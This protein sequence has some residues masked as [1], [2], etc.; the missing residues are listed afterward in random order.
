MKTR[1][2][3]IIVYAISIFIAL[4]QV[5]LILIHTHLAVQQTVHSINPNSRFMPTEYNHAQVNFPIN[6]T[7]CF[8][9]KIVC[10]TASSTQ[11]CIIVMKD[12]KNADQHICYQ[13]GEHLRQCMITNGTHQFTTHMH[14]T[15]PSSLLL[16]LICFE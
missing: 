5:Q 6:S 15:S 14:T 4:Q 11:T 3:A 12:G 13:Q 1:I 7:T 16:R 8:P 10:N 2:P 9:S